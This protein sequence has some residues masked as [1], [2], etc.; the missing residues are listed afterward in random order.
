MKFK[1]STGSGSMARGASPGTRQTV[2]GACI[3]EN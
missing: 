1:D 2:L 3:I